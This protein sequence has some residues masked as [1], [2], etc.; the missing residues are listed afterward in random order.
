MKPATGF[1]VGVASPDDCPKEKL[2][3]LGGGAG[4]VPN[5]NGLV[6]EGVV[7][8]KGF[9]KSVPAPKLKLNPPDGGGAAGVVVEGAGVAPKVKGAPLLAVEGAAPKEKG[10]GV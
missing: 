6:G 3:A 8:W 5:V 1:A 4:P 2:G 10:A 9:F 7:A